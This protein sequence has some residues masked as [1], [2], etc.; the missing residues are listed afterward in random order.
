V[1]AGNYKGVTDSS[2]LYFSQNKKGEELIS[3]FPGATIETDMMKEEETDVV[4]STHDVL[5]VIG[6]KDILVAG[7]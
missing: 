6:N 1:D 5:I 2:K 7:P 3:L 4:I